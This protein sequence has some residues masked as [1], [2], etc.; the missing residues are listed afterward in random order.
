MVD[1][2]KI[3]ELAANVKANPDDSFAKFVLALEF[4]KQDDLEKAR[5]FF[6]NIYQNDPEY[7]GVYY[8]LGKLYERMEQLEK[9]SKI[10]REGI[11]AAA[12]QNE[13]RTLK[14][15]KESLATL[16]MEME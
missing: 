9:A 12:A 7:V 8:H 13:K 1:K 5:L 6:E 15:L 16:K 10:Y 4:I 3:K 14:E 2:N 11:E